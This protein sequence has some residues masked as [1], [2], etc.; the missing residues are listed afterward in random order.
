MKLQEYIKKSGKKWCV[1]SHETNKKIACFDSEAEAKAGLKRMQKFKHMKQA[2]ADIIMEGNSWNSHVQLFLVTEYGLDIDVAEDIVSAG[3]DKG[4][5]KGIMDSHGI[6]ARLQ[7]EYIQ[8]VDWVKK[9]LDYR[10]AAKQLARA[11][12]EEFAIELL[13]E[14]EGGW[15]WNICVIESGMSKNRTIYGE[16]AMND[17]L[18]LIKTAEDEGQPIAVMC[19][20]YEEITDYLNHLGADWRNVVPEGFPKKT[21]GWLRQ[22]EL[23][24]DNGKQKLIAELTISEHEEWLKDLITSAHREG[25]KKPFG[26]SIDG[27]GLVEED[28]QEG[29]KVWHIR[30]VHQ[31]L[32]VTVVTFPS[33]GGEIINPK[34]SERFYALAEN[35]FNILERDREMDFFK[36]IIEKLKELFGE[37]VKDGEGLEAAQEALKVAENKD[38][39]MKFELNK[40]N[41]E[42]IYGK[43]KACAYDIKM[44]KGLREMSAIKDQMAEI[45]DGIK[46]TQ[47]S[48]PEEKPNEKPEP[49]TVKLEET[50]AYKELK[51]QSEILTVSNNDVLVE[52]VLNESK[53]TVKGK[54]IV[55]G[56]FKGQQTLDE[57]K[58]RKAVLDLEE[59]FVALDS[60]GEKLPVEITETEQ[61]KQKEFYQKQM[62]VLM[63]VPEVD[64]DGNETI[65]SFKESSFT[66]IKDLYIRWTGDK[67]V[68]GQ[69]SAPMGRSRISEAIAV[70]DF[71]TM[72]G[73]S[74]TKHMVMEYDKQSDIWR[75]ICKVRPIPDF[76]QQDFIQFGAYADLATVA[77]NASYA[78]FATPTEETGSYSPTK[79]GN[80]ISI[81]REAILNDDLRQFA[82][83]AQRIGRAAN[84]TL[85]KFVFDLLL[86]YTSAVNDTN[87]YDATVLYTAGHANY[88]TDALSI[89]TFRAARVA[90]FKQQDLDSK[91]VYG[92]TPKYLVVPIDLQATARVILESKYLPGGANNDINSEFGVAE[93]LVSEYLRADTNNWFVVADPGRWDTIEVGFVQGKEKPGLFIQNTE[94]AGMVFSHDKISYK[95]RHEYGGAVTDFRTMYGSIVA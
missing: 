57:A 9:E 94:T 50:E 19:Y 39:R 29:E 64:K 33:A 84:T 60:G 78:E 61:G 36:Q 93:V 17:I 34:E 73:T 49:K 88:A 46:K 83:T 76:K 25:I 42:E 62:D 87:I 8:F 56:N 24:E 63:Y 14:Q 26:L 7:L 58:L 20:D 1:F 74:M 41:G 67:E 85:S 75:K 18:G 59:A 10:N 82:K 86:S 23:I 90:M 6:A 70:S 32:E 69:I 48:K 38:P 4:V 54:N 47:E 68:S 27:E 51:K 2:V 65:R 81:S 55:R 5:I 13:E 35:Y 43:V 15:N 95:V 72:L 92:I 31:L 37:E 40:E 77:E 44:E 3:L 53:L 22:A 21:V 89:T 12:K 16:D 91:D 28:M 30:R 52:S 11:V 71:S 80:F 79:R 66:G 45:F